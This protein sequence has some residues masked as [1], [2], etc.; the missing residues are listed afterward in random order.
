MHRDVHHPSLGKSQGMEHPSEP[1]KPEHTP[2]NDTTELHEILQR[3]NN[4][5]ANGQPVRPVTA[6]TI[7]STHEDGNT[8]TPSKHGVDLQPDPMPPPETQTLLHRDDH[9]TTP[10]TTPSDTIVSP[11]P[12]LGLPPPGTQPLPER[13][14][15]DTPP[16]TTPSDIV[17]SPQP[18]PGIPQVGT[19]QAIL[20]GSCAIL[21]I[22]FAIL[23]GAR[24]EK[25]MSPLAFRVYF[26]A[27]EAKYWR[28]HTEE[29]ETYHYEPYGFQ[30]S[31]VGRLLP[32]VSAPQ[33]SR[34]F[35][36]L[37][38][39]NIL[40]VSD[41]GIRFAESLDDVTI[42]E[43]V[44][45]RATSMFEQLHP[46]TRDTLVKIPRRLLKLLVH[47]GRR[48]VRAATLIG[49]L[50]TTMLTKRTEKYQGYKGCCKAIWIAQLFSVNAKRVN[51]ERAR[52]I[53]EGWFRRLP[54]PQRVRNRWGEWVA[55][56]LTPSELPQEPVDNSTPDG[57]KVQ[58][59]LSD[60]APKLQPPLKEPVPPAELE[61]NQA[62]SQG[63]QKPGA[64][65]PPQ[66]L[67]EPTWDNILLAD[68]TDDDRS[69]ALFQQAV[70]R[71][72]LTPATHD[73]V[74]FF[75]AIVHTTHV[76][77]TNPGGFLRVIVEQGLWHHL[78]NTEEDA[79]LK[80]LNRYLE[81][82]TD[83]TPALESL[84]IG[85]TSTGVRQSHPQP[86]VLSEDAL[87]VQGLTEA[88]DR[89]GFK[90]DIFRTVKLHG[91]LPDW[92]KA[93]WEQAEKEVA[94]AHKFRARQRS[95]AMNMTGMHEMIGGEDMDEDDEQIDWD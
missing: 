41:N 53:A 70:D 26:A 76:A 93:R 57:S 8:T 12:D 38:A 34:A 48:L 72:F 55:L 23:W 95:Q 80:R 47:C 85:N 65:Q 84:G 39:T 24:K 75:T 94:E 13:D 54:T 56:N 91:H 5:Y 52:L 67:K 16:R 64:S 87:R 9:D 46:D 22:Q 78:T 50:L 1:R 74:E 60:S 15:H 42:T 71:G 69:M 28:C 49:I 33:I 61:E 36:E 10:H 89:A 18:D 59:P 35:G 11:E 63:D 19:Y 62:L 25:E 6:D 77:L 90:G 88:L 3:L 4:T 30:P 32:G 73:Q 66:H 43:Q 81:S 27:H 21:P 2:D 68:L 45:R 40:T 83:N 17:V 51:L 31:D 58:P 29:G 92:D 37:E 20:G 79:A 7:L 82:H 86:I 44:K 14:D